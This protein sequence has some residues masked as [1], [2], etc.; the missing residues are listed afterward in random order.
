MDREPHR[1]IH[2][3]TRLDHGGSAENTMVT[4][5]RHDKARFT[6]IVVAGFPGRWDAQGGQAATDANCSRLD[7]CGVRWQLIPTL[8]R[9]ISPLADLQALRSLIR[10]FRREKPALVHTHTS[11]AGLLGRIAAAIVGVPAVIHTPHG[12]VFYGHFSPLLSRLLLFIERFLSRFTQRLVALT[13]SER[14]DHLQ[15]KV[16]K[17]ET[18]AVIPSGI[19]LERFTRRERVAGQ[20][21]ALFGCPSDAFVVGSVGWLTDIKGHR[22]LV[23][24]VARVIQEFPRLHVVIAGSGGLGSNLERLAR[25]LEM[26]QAL[27]LL[28]HR[29][30][31]EGCLGAMDLFVLPSLNEGMGRALVEAMAAGLPVIATKVGG[32]PALIDHDRTGLLVPPADSAALADALRLLLRRP[33]EAER[34]GRAAQAAI[35]EQFSA[36]SMVRALE[37]LYQETLVEVG[38]W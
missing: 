32:V 10:L 28:G 34:L 33:E 14:E 31:V 21:A 18:F 7:Q 15:R 6:P 30:D 20:K 5:L 23:E 12:H 9:P 26:Q 27:H 1:I 29:D 22:Y 2:V 3:I 16:G 24:A 8:V 13:E 35:T 36:D 37:R 25:E 19:D 11:K 38:A 17:A 4:A